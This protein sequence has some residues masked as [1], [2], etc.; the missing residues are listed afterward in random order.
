MGLL[1]DVGDALGLSAPD[2]TSASAELSPEQ[3]RFRSNLRDTVMTQMESPGDSPIVQAMRQGA[4]EQIASQR[5]NTEEQLTSGLEKRGLNDSG[6]AVEGL[7]NAG[8]NA[9]QSQVEAERGLQDTITNLRQQ[10]LQSGLNLS[11]QDVNLAQGKAQAQN[12]QAIAE[13]EARGGLT[14]A[15]IGSG[16]AEKG[17]EGLGSA[18]G[19]G[20]LG[21][22][23]VTGFTG[24]AASTGLSGQIGSGLSS[25]MTGVASMF[26]DKRL[27]KDIEY[28][29]EE[30]AGVPVVE[31]E[32]N[33]Q[34]EDLGLE[35]DERHRGVLAEDVEKHYP[36]LV[37]TR[38]GYKA[39]RVSE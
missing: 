18:L 35:S 27:K 30:V 3:E 22:K 25:A 9:L 28:T 23:N 17:V 8:R 21:L 6:I 32:W 29:G 24:G 20:G 39:I 37:T 12:K 38:E 36:E 2:M 1:G 10:G 4:R 19:T 34:A 26:S 16:A 5:Q 11:G 14:G 33:E 31:F 15:L 7:Q 13:N